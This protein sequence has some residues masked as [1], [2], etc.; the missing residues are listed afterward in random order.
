METVGLAAK[1]SSSQLSHYRFQRRELRPYD[2]AFEVLYCGLTV[3]DTQAMTNEHFTTHFPLVPGS[4]MVG[5]VVEIGADVTCFAVGDHVAVGAVVDSCLACEACYAADEHLC[6]E[7]ATEASNGT[8]RVTGEI[9]RGGLSRYNVVRE[10]FVFPLP[11]GMEIETAAPLL[12]AGVAAFAPL[13]EHTKKGARVAV[14]GFGGIGHLVTKL[15]LLFDV[16]VSVFSRTPE[17]E[18]DAVSLG[19]AAFH[20]FD[21]REAESLEHA[22][23]SFD[24]VVDTIPV[25]HDPTRLLSLLDVGGTYYLSGHPDS[26]QEIDLAPVAS[27]RRRIVQSTAG[28]SRLTKQV[29]AA[30]AV[31]RLAPTCEVICAGDLPAYID[32]LRHSQARYC[33][34]VDMTTLE[35]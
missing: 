10:D 30:C 20:H 29:L 18:Q 24:L 28:G 1:T 11:D 23:N 5:R 27:G 12:G 32:K 9:T 7:G 14:F 3:A 2:V 15:A 31:N 19:A 35:R 26:L 17:K 21:L 4:H 34:V 8:D 25:K 22:H 33:V 13:R 16:E 6:V